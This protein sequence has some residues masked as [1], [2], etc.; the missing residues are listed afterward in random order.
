[1]SCPAFLHHARLLSTRAIGA[2]KSYKPVTPSLRHRVIIDKSGLWRG[3]PESSLTERISGLHQGGRNNS[4]KIT[5]RGRMAPKH[6]RQYRIID[7]H[8]QRSDPAEVKRLEYD[9][10]RSAFIALVRYEEEPN[11]GYILAP[12]GLEVGATV[13]CNEGAPF[14]P[15]NAMSLA[16]IPDGSQVHNIEFIPGHGGKMCRS[17]GTSAKLQSKD[18]KY[19]LL[20]LQSGEVRRVLLN[21][22]A[23]IGV[24]SNENHKHRVLGKAG[25]SAWIGRRSKVRGVAM[26]PVDHPM[27]GGEGKSSGGRPSSSP[28]GWFTKGIRTRC[29][30]G[31]HSS[32]LILR[33]R[34]HEKLKLSN[35]NRGSW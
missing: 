28:W 20:K 5:V 1:M 19:A 27:G 2:L 9:P 15:G 7:F 29:T 18:G 21:C 3:R 24:V 16:L 30:K 6:R 4:G 10:N 13:Q 26:N 25:A 14:T 33:R 23:T 35:V 31:K 22:R 17:A 34:N 12:K 8:R 11:L 32:K